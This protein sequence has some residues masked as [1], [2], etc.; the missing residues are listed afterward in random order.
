MISPSLHRYALGIYA[1]I[2]IQVVPQYEDVVMTF[3][4][5]V[6]VEELDL[7]SEFCTSDYGRFAQATIFHL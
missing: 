5:M 4:F 1:Y 2:V 7:I 3:T 6:I